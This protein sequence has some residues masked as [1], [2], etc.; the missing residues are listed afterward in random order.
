MKPGKMVLLV[1]SLAATVMSCASFHGYKLLVQTPSGALYSKHDDF[2]NETLVENGYFIAHSNWSL[3]AMVGENVVGK[4]FVL[5]FQNRRGYWAYRG[6]VFLVNELGDSMS[7]HSTAEEGGHSPINFAEN[8]DVEVTPLSDSQVT[9][10]YGLLK[11]G[12]QTSVTLG[13]QEYEVNQEAS[14]AILETID[15]YKSLKKFVE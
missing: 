14:T 11:N 12:K 2:R 8:R 10:L 13:G 9:Q 4:F 1:L 5:L 15:Y 6:N 7:W 3:G